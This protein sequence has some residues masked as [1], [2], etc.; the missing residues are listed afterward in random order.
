MSQHLPS[1]SV[2]SDLVT[3]VTA[4]G[5]FP[6]EA[7]DCSSVCSLPSTVTSAT[8]VKERSSPS[9]SSAFPS[10][11]SVSRPNAPLGLGWNR[12]SVFLGGIG[13]DLNVGI[14]TAVAS[15]AIEKGGV[16]GRGRDV[17]VSTPL[18]CT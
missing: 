13:D 5:S 6:T 10:F 9:E 16:A 12:V 1:L 3:L 14:G 17:G 8:G 4:I 15:G 11:A 2:D 7:G 18:G